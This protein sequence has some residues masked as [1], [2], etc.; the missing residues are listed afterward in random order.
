MKFNDE[1]IEAMMKSADDKQGIENA[2]LKFNAEY[3]RND[4]LEFD[5]W[6]IR[7]VF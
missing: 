1:Y 7:N 5:N 3:A 4:A 2:K 6:R